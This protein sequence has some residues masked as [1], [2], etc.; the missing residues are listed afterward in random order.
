MRTARHFESPEDLGRIASGEIGIWA[1]KWRAIDWFFAVNLVL[2]VGVWVGANHERYFRLVAAGRMGE[3]VVYAGLLLCALVGLWMGLRRFVIDPGVLATAQVVV[4]MHFAGGLVSFGG[5]RL[6]GHVFCG[7]RFD[8]F[9]HVAAAFAIAAV[10]ADVLAAEGVR[11]SEL[12]R[13][14]VA[15]AALGA[16]CLVEIYEYLVTQTMPALTTARFEDS[17]RDL[18]AD[19][20]GAVLW[21]LVS[22]RLVRS[23]FGRGDP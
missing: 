12:L 4:L 16:G 1:A 19:A 21:W 8:K 23:F 3:F 9:V 17:L 18:T 20:V 11:E 10:L 7:I 6:Y 5:E 15:M 14:V 22:T 2:A 13:V